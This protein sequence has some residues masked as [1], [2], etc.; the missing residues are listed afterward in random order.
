[1]LR[2]HS[3]LTLILSCS[4][5]FELYPHDTQ[6]C[7]MQIESRECFV[8]FLVLV[9]LSCFMTFLTFSTVSHTNADLVFMWQD[10]NPLIVDENIELPQ[11]DLVANVTGDCTQIYST[12][13]SPRC[14]DTFN[15]FL[16][17]FLLDAHLFFMSSS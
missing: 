13:T 10:L 6:Q 5:N 9:F 16:L 8:L 1:M 17:F 14:L 4:M 15:C 2:F 11:L 12:G 7:K 3:R